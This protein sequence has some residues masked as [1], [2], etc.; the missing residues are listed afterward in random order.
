MKNPCTWW[1]R[2]Q[3]CEHLQAS[4]GYPSTSPYPENE[5]CFGVGFVSFWGW[6]CQKYPVNKSALRFSTLHS[7][8]KSARREYTDEIKK[9]YLHTSGLVGLSLEDLLQLQNRR[10]VCRTQAD[11]FETPD[12]LKPPLIYFNQ[13]Y[14]FLPGF[15]LWLNSII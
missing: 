14:H 5:Q 1:V 6:L 11:R 13:H 10:V 3:F 9:H 7:A 2:L 4:L 15:K 8:S 12:C